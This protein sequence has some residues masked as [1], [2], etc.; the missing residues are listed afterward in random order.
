MR[1]LLATG[2]CGVGLMLALPASAGADGAPAGP[3]LGGAG[4]SAPR[5]AFNYVALT[6]GRHTLLE[7]VRRAGAAVEDTRLLSGNLAVPGATAAGDGTG[8]SAD[9]R[10]LVLT[11]IASAYSGRR[12]LLTVL[13][14]RRLRVRARIALRG[15]LAVDAISPDGRWLYLLHYRQATDPLR[16][17]V[18]AYDLRTGRM[19]AKPIVDPREPDEKMLGIPMARATS[20]DGRWVYTLYQRP[21]GSPF[22]HA[23]DTSGRTAACIDLPMFAAA[24][25]LG[26][27]LSRDGRTLHVGKALVDTRTF[28]GA[29]PRKPAPPGRHDTPWAL[30]LIVAPALLAGV[31]LLARRRRRPQAVAASPSASKS[32]A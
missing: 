27:R 16:Y 32:S 10:T 12:T 20:P 28:A 23:L 25:G 18:R 29:V 6:V 30:P 4:V 19:L 31:G 14:A 5:G 17:E 21:E 1:R 11:D 26:L 24:D 15:H 3:L 8:L 7:R 2:C 13:D 9:G 22:V